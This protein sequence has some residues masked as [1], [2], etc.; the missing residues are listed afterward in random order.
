MEPRE[1][2]RLGVTEQ[3][4]ASTSSPWASPAMARSPRRSWEKLNMPGAPV[5]ESRE[6]GAESAEGRAPREQS[7]EQRG[8]SR[9]R[10]AKSH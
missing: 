6:Q 3:L 10:K 1:G 9:E 7:T 4:E 2:A 8:E 5:T